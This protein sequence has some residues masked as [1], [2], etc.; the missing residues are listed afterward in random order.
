MTTYM[1][2]MA[3][4][5]AEKDRDELQALR[6]ENEALRGAVAEFAQV[7][8]NETFDDTHR[9]VCLKVRL[10]TAYGELFNPILKAREV[11]K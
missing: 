2:Y 3:R 7:I 6:A 8:E 9:G 11:G 4:K 10:L 5:A 1:A